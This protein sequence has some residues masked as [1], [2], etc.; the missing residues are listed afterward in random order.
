MSSRKR[1]EILTLGNLRN[2]LRRYG[3]TLIPTTK[4]KCMEELILYLGEEEPLDNPVEDQT[5]EIGKTPGQP[6][7]AN[8]QKLVRF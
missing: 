5:H 6:S 2:E 8:Q 7:S 4:A 3:V 1:L